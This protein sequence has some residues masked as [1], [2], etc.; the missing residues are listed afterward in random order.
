MNVI[1]L[2]EHL[3]REWKSV[4]RLKKQF[5]KK[6]IN[7]KVFNI[8]FEMSK[9]ITYAHFNKID[10]LFLPWIRDDYDEKII[11]RLL[12]T[13]D[14]MIVINLHHEQIMNKANVFDYIPFSEYARNGVYHFAWGDYFKDFLIKH[15]VDEN[16]IR[17]VGNMRLEDRFVNSD[18]NELADKYGLDKNKRWIL[19]ADNRGTWDKMTPKDLRKFVKYGYD[20]N[21]MSQQTKLE[22]STL[23]ALV[24]ELKTIP[25]EIGDKYE[26]IY[27]PHPFADF[28]YSFKYVHVIAAESIYDWI[29]EVELFITFGSTS[30]F[31][32]DM[33]GVPSMTH[34]LERVPA[35]FIIEGVNEYPKLISFSSIND[36]LISNVKK[37]CDEKNIYKKYIGKYTDNVAQIYVNTALELTKD[38][39]SVTIKYSQMSRLSMYKLYLREFVTYYLVKSGLFIKIQWPLMA[40]AKIGDLPFYKENNWIYDNNLGGKR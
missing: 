35:E 19:F 9:A 10:I 2:Y 16:R 5:K 24:N 37:E 40:V 14:K 12:M 32:A 11:S 27:R 13:N 22:N 20:A 7:A 21:K 36:I 30:I 34:G 18:R 17:V 4:Q 6:H 29:N 15:G 3:M 28:D 33:C 23:E 39:S 25:Q 8:Y 1:I 38:K 26:I 31:E